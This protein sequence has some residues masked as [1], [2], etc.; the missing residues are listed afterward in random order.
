MAPRIEDLCHDHSIITSGSVH[1]D[2][3]SESVTGLHYTKEELLSF[4]SVK[5]GN[6]TEKTGPSVIIEKQPSVTFKDK[7]LE[8]VKPDQSQGT[9]RVEPQGDGTD[10]DL[11][12][13]IFEKK[14]KKKK[15]KSSGKNK[16]KKDGPNGFEGKSLPPTIYDDMLTMCYRVFR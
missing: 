3:N 8:D 9:G 2:Q 10:N 14:K 12:E 4:K 7:K 13:V 1:H 5:D 6:L 15:K 11:D 16:N